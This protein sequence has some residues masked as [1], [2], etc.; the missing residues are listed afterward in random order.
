MSIFKLSALFSKKLG[1]LPPGVR[2]KIVNVT[3]EPESDAPTDYAPSPF[4]NPPTLVSKDD[5][6]FEPG[7]RVGPGP[8]RAVPS[9]IMPEDSEELKEWKQNFKMD[10][11]AE[12]IV[13]KTEPEAARARAE[14]ARARGDVHTF[15]P[16]K[17]MLLLLKESMPILKEIPSIWDKVVNFNILAS[18][19]FGNIEIV[20]IF[21]GE[22]GSNTIEY[23][24]FDQA[25]A[26]YRKSSSSE[27]ISINTNNFMAIRSAIN[28]EEMQEEKEK[29]EEKKPDAKKNK[30]RRS[31]TQG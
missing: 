7:S 16:S 20:P 13:Y 15:T 10:D 11:P 30:G 19:N 18:G 27:G 28:N 31:F 12:S 6:V 25:R 29:K 9:T 5:E 23:W 8:E 21:I 26:R 17:E 2:R 14:A 3:P 22:E 24:I 4:I 1:A